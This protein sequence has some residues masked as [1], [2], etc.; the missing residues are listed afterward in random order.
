MP[1]EEQYNVLVEKHREEVARQIDESR[2]RAAE[3]RPLKSS[4]SMP[5]VTATI[6][7]QA[8]PKTV[9]PIERKTA[10]EGWT[11]QNVA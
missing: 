3:S 4:S 6:S 11:P 5:T 2:K 1:S 10:E 8:S 9:R 7:T